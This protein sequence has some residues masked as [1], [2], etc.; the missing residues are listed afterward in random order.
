MTTSMTTSTTTSGSGSPAAGTLAAARLLLD[1]MGISPADLVGITPVAPT[2]AEV[3]PAV[4]A[5]LKPGTARTYGIHLTRLETEWATLRV[6]DPARADI[7]DMARAVQA[8]ARAN[9][10][11]RGGTSAVEHLVS[12]V[13]CVY[14]YAEDHGWIRPADNPA[15][16]VP[17]PARKASPRYAIPSGQLAEIC[18]TA[19]TTG[20][21]PELDALILRL[22]IETACRRGGALALRPHDLDPDRCLVWL[23]EKDGTDRWQP[24]SPTLM[25]HLRDH[26]RDRYAS[27]SG[28]LLR[29]P[30]GRPITARR[31]DHL[32][33][34]IGEELP[35][36]ALQGV[37]A[38]WLRHT[39]LTWVER[40]FG[41][42]VARAYAGHHGKNPGTTTTYVKA[43]VLEVAAAL[44]VLTDHPATA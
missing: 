26:A 17:I 23:R 3:I 5:T 2:F 1:Q 19:A 37:T 12:T 9:R 35:W 43:D 36:V 16:T 7:E 21:D 39:T 24:V 40:T 44:A 38:H 6:I 14:R 15:R 42:A 29:Y 33:A 28:Q 32:W 20:N 41:Y 13:R 18:H 30:N 34:R 31:Y 4:R 11:S 22:H 25:R 10:A 27:Q 8:A